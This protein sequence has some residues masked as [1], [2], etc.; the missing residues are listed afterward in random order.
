VAEPAGADG[1]EPLRI[2]FVCQTDF[3]SPSEKQALWVSEELVRQGHAV[4]VSLGGDPATAAFEGVEAGDGLTLTGHRFAGP[5]LRADARAAAR[6]FRPDAIYAF[7]ARVPVIAAARAYA[8]ATAAPVFV[9]FE[10]DEWGLAS[11]PPVRSAYRRAARLGR[12]LLWRLHP[13]WW[14]YARP[15]TLRWVARHARGL[16]ALTPALAR[17]VGERLGREAAVVLPASPHKPPA[18]AP[19][20]LELPSAMNGRPLLAYTGAVH[21]ANRGDLLICLRAVAEL[22]RR[23]YDVAFAH[24]GGI[25]RRIDPDR[26]VAEAGLPDDAACFLGYLPPE[27]HAALLRAAA[28]LLQPGEPNPFNRLRLPAKLQAY[29]ASGT[30]TVTF[31]VGSGELLHDGTEVLKTETGDPAELADRVAALLDDAELRAALARG[32]PAA[33]QR[34]FDAERNARALVDHFRAGLAMATT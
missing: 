22:L 33:A 24:A 32:G 20:R 14:H 15:T 31:A 7:N 30:P 8:G 34:L 25:M 16:D 23:G 4:L 9:H 19:E 26:L 13:P 6:R 29:L 2:L 28:V 3:R 1:G 5:R 10:D 18:P 17:A 21:D 12:L 27:A 11:G